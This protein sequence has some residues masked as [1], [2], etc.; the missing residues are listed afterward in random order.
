MT[1]RK[2]LLLFLGFTSSYSFVIHN[3]S[4]SGFNCCRSFILQNNEL[5]HDSRM[6][7][8]DEKATSV[9]YQSCVNTGNSICNF[10]SD[11]DGCG[12]TSRRK[13]LLS[14]AGSSVCAFG[15][16]MNTKEAVAVSG[17]TISGDNDVGA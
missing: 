8:G 12:S 1:I 10:K 14:L 6:D 17:F 4:S 15:F 9:A 13:A 16:L 3:P 2:I 5:S 11:A 7:Y